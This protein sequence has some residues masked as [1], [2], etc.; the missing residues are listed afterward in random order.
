MLPF[1]DKIEVVVFSTCK[2]AYTHVHTPQTV[3]DPGPGEGSLIAGWPF[4]LTMMWWVGLC[5]DIP[6]GK[7][8][9]LKSF[10][11]TRLAILALPHNSAYFEI[12]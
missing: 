7:R 6:G 10:F 8:D 3:Y 5:G 2:S 12:N 1:S 9:F 4:S 11:I